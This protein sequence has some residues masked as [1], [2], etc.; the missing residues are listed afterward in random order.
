MTKQPLTNFYINVVNI[1]TLYNIKWMGLVYIL[2][3]K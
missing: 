2:K 3:Y 1:L